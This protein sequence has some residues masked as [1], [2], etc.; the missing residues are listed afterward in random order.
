MLTYRIHICPTSQ[1]YFRKII[2]YLNSLSI[3]IRW[4]FIIYFKEKDTM[5]KSS[6]K[7]EL[8]KVSALSHTYLTGKTNNVAKNQPQRKY[9]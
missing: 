2:S 5:N 8:K 1:R 3:M 7:S 6:I 9:G 4:R